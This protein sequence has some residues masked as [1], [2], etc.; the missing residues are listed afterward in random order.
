MQNA[1]VDFVVYGHVHA[2][3]TTWPVY[4]GTVMQRNYADPL[5]PIHLLLG[6]GGAAFQGQWRPQ[7]AWSSFRDLSWGYS[8]LRFVNATLARFSYIAFNT[9]DVLHSFDVTRST[10]PSHA[11]R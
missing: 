1:T 9:S 4:N 11:W 10:T 3:E 6:T 8:S 7:P 5:A 2:V